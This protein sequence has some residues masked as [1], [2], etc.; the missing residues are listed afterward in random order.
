[1]G[2]PA[3]SY[4]AERGPVNLST[5]AS[6]PGDPLAGLLKATCICLAEIWPDG[7]PT[8]AS[9]LTL[10][11]R[12]AHA[13]LHV[14]VLGQF[15]RGK[16]TFI[17]ALLGEPFLPA[18][19]V[20]ATAIPTF[21]TWASQ[22]YARITYRD[23]RVDEARFAGVA[24]IRDH[25]QQFVTEDGN[26]MNRRGVARA[27]LYA[28]AEILRN[29]IVLIDTPGVGSTLRHNTEAALNVLPECDAALFVLS[30]DPPI[31]EAEIAYLAEVRQHVVQLF[32][33]LNKMD[34]FDGTEREDALAFLAAALRRS[35]QDDGASRIFPV[36]AREALAAQRRRDE[37]ALEA[38]GIERLKREILESLARDK[39]AALEASVRAKAATQLGLALSDL[40]LQIRTLELPLEDLEERARLLESIVRD[41]ER[42]RQIAQ[43]LLEGD[44]RRAI[45]ELERQAEQ[46]RQDSRAHLRA[47]IEQTALGN[48]RVFDQ[49]S[50]QSAVSAAIPLFFELRLAAVAAEFR[51]MVEELLWRHQARADELVASLRRSAAALFDVPLCE[52]ESTEP[53]RLGP[54]PYWVTQKWNDALVPAAATLLARILPAE[55]QQRRLRRQMDE[56]VDQLVQH[57]VENLRWATLR[58]VT[59]TFRRFSAQLESRLR[60]VLAVT[61]QT[62]HRTIERRRSRADATAPEL[63]QALHACETLDGL[64]AAF[65]GDRQT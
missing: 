39:V 21:I 58:G 7:H 52:A 62:V 19:V 32:F 10:Q 30:A 15:K 60:E 40:K 50:A 49:E 41:T 11:E 57:N 24:E 18:A 22:T 27:D 55:Q 16:S 31:T 26:P 46:L 25:L 12:L 8:H 5:G 20:P 13:R 4:T 36:S 33:I 45:A 35:G 23:N 42:E 29:G 59:E 51:R 1:M 48:Q 43:D 6:S 56:Q 14:A 53:F 28:A 37:V 61:K 2:Q 64:A 34:Y 54:E 47:V 63:A 3:H 65:G 17:N 44:R 38:S 9:L